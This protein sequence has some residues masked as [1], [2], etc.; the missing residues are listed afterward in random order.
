VGHEAGRRGAVPVILARLEEHPVTG[1]DHLDRGAAPLR[2]ADTLEDVD[3]LAVRV[4]V[5]G[6]PRARC[7]VDAARTDA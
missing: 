6:R 3:G 7:E 5:P 4:R 2:E 1:A